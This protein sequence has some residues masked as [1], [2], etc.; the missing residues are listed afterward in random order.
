MLPNSLLYFT[1]YCD[2]L[3]AM[4]VNSCFPCLMPVY[5]A[6]SETVT[7]YVA[8][9]ACFVEGMDSDKLEK[10]ADYKCWQ[11]LSFSKINYASQDLLSLISTLSKQT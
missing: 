1:Q 7:D 2:D 4:Q 10:A 9:D 11:H 5:A 3:A 8:L 6:T